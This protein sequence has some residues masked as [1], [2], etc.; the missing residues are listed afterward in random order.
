MEE[1]KIIEKRI[2]ESDIHEEVELEAFEKCPIC[3]SEAYH[4]VLKLIKGKWT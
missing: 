3:G 1:N 2:C 4:H